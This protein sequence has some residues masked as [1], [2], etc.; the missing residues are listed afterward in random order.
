MPDLFKEPDYN[1]IQLLYGFVLLSIAVMMATYLFGNVYAIT[2]V[3]CMLLIKD[4]FPNFIIGA[5][6]V[7]NGHDKKKEG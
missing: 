6:K 4:G 5:R 3:V 1:G 2:A 7:A